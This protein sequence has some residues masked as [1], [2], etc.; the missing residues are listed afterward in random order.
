MT[1]RRPHLIVPLLAFLAF[2]LF[3]QHA[4][5]AL[6]FH[7][8]LGFSLMPGANSAP[9]SFHMVRRY[10]DPARGIQVSNITQASFV[11]IAVGWG[12]SS[13]NPNHENLFDNYGI[14]NCGYRGDTIIH[15]VF[16]KGGVQCNP[17][18]NLWRLLYNEYPAFSPPPKSNQPS[19]NTPGT[20][21]GWAKHVN[22]PSDG[23]TSILQQYGVNHYSDIIYGDN[24]FRLIHDM[25]DPEWES[26]Y[27]GS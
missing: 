22:H 14:T 15:R 24:A 17:V 20:G 25:Q 7:D 9:V 27:R 12:E 26:K 18:D 1:R 4:G 6:T 2:L 8:E 16:Y 11:A 19:V 5:P 21:P 13:A 3:T 23:Q 10:D